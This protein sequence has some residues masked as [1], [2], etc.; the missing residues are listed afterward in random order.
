MATFITPQIWLHSSLHKYGYIHHILWYCVY[1][2][3][4]I[5]IT[6]CDISCRDITLVITFCHI[7]L[8]NITIFITFSRM[9]CINITL[10]MTFCHIVLTNVTTF[11]TC[12]YCL[13]N[14]YNITA[15]MTFLCDIMSVTVI[16]YHIVPS[17]IQFTTL[18]VVLCPQI[19]ND[20]LTCRIV[21]KY[22]FNY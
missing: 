22:Q 19:W 14:H 2:N 13:C 12:C 16:I 21:Y 10:V 9:S 15:L 20:D 4:T 8:I 18:F 5:L 6:F 1:I 11:I 3:I 17:G 7:V